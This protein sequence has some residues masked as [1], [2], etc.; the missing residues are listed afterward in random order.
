MHALFKHIGEH[1]D[2]EAIEED[3][4]GIV[5]ESLVDVRLI[6]TVNARI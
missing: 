5:E 4:C 3:F 1:W 2:E 6:D